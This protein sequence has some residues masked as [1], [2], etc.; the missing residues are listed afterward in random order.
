MNT[1]VG[2]LSEFATFIIRTM[3]Y[4]FIFAFLVVLVA[5]IFVAAS[6]SRTTSPQPDNNAMA[7]AT[8]APAT[9]DSKSS[10][11]DVFD[12]VEVVKTEA[13]WKQLLTPAQYNI[14][15]EAGTERPF[16][17]EYANNHED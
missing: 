7:T 14:L 17:G 5:G 9:N 15:R 10:S 16:T 6:C 12:G 1:I 13:E 8:P 3:K 11:D 4:K 2:I